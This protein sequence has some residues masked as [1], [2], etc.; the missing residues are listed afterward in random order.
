MSTCPS[1]TSS[2]LFAALLLAATLAPPALAQSGVPSLAELELGVRGTTVR[3]EE[4]VPA[5]PKGVAAALRVVASAGGHELTVEGL[6]RFLGNGGE[7]AD[8]QVQGELSGP[9]LSGTLTLPDA[10]SPANVNV[11]ALP[12]PALVPAGDYRLSNLRVV[13]GG[14]AVLD[15]EPRETTLRVIDQVMVTRVSTRPLTLDEIRERGIVLDSE[16][17]LGFEFAVALRLD[18]K[19]VPFTFP[20]V[21]QREGV[22]L[23]L[24]LVPPG[25]PL[26]EGVTPPRIFQPV[27]MHFTGGGEAELGPTPKLDLGEDGSY[28]TVPGLLVIPGEVGYL[29]QFFSAKLYVA[30]G[31]PEGSHLSLEDIRARVK[32]PPGADG[33]LGTEDDPLSLPEILRDG[34][35][36]PQ[37]LELPVQLTGEDGQPTAEE[38]L[39]PGQQGLAEY[40]LRGDQEGF[41]RLDFDLTATLLGVPGPGGEPRD[42][43]VKGKASGGVLVRNPYFHMS[44]TVPTVVRDQEPFKLF[45]TVTNMGQSAAN[46]FHVQLNT[47]SGLVLASGSD[48]PAR[49][50]VDELQP[51]DSRT[52]EYRCV[53]QR[54]G[55]V[56]AKYLALV[57]SNASGSY[58]TLNF[59]LGIDERGVPLSPDTLA[60]PEAVNALP[61]DVVQAAMRVLGQAWSAA[62]APLGSL[63]AGIK[64]VP[65]QV[66]VIKGLALAEAGLRVQLRG[67]DPAVAS[68]DALRELFADFVR[69]ERLAPDVPE[70]ASF[71]Q[72]LRQTEAGRNLLAR[73]GA[74]LGGGVPAGGALDYEQALSEVLASGQDFLAFAADLGSPRAADLT[75]FDG[76]GQ[77]SQ[78]RADDWQP[79]FGL[80]SVAALPLG[81]ASAPLLGFVARPRGAYLLELLGRQSGQGQVSV[82]YPAG[83]G[84]L[85]AR[86]RHG[87]RPAARQPHLDRDRPRRSRS[88]CWCRRTSTATAWPTNRRWSTR[89]GPS[90]GRDRACS[91]PPW[92]VRRPSPRRASSACTPRS[93]STGRSSPVR[94]RTSGTSPSRARHFLPTAWWGP[95]ASSRDAWSSR[96]WRPPRGRTG[97]RR[98]ASPASR[99]CAG[100]SARA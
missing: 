62:K 90:R 91:R 49:R 20:V 46:L 17:Y 74:H 65:Q 40:V 76:T 12:L 11:L 58:G 2:R 54:T 61:L 84:E 5:V 71:D 86:G 14:Q 3:L 83:D 47:P 53:S 99:T 35:P 10:S 19:E 23:P 7:P 42:V 68:R 39:M 15:V 59:T 69:P 79:V 88:A 21:F 32:L 33:V 80:P 31:A 77:S 70:D 55:Q 4:A 8:F 51:G 66:V 34:Q 16:A 9:G 78:V 50:D 1:I 48:N 100:T 41:H 97:R 56:V 13:V 22:A 85:P 37:A 38:R 72:L 98:S 89:P 52:F 94:P 82:S 25:P 73:I 81:E 60:L 29:K 44:F 87:P 57:G 67:G 45:V 36:T 24:E 95:S 6:R 43:P 18:S 26:R 30:N 93:S 27:L 96:S 92:W 63:P 28:A 75:L 64:R